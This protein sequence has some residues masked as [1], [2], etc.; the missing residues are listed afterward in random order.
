[1]KTPY[2]PS[3]TSP[4]DFNVEETNK[5]LTLR[6][7]PA[8][9][10]ELGAHQVENLHIGVPFYVVRDASTNPVLSMMLGTTENGLIKVAQ[11]G[12]GRVSFST[13]AIGS[14]FRCFAANVKV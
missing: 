6:K 4:A 5:V 9:G 2:I 7:Y 14:K 10:V 3:G 13:A 8:V 11:G 1:M 12:A